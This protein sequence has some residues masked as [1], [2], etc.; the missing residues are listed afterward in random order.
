MGEKLAFES[1]FMIAEGG[2]IRYYMCCD[3]H[4]K[5]LREAWRSSAEDGDGCG[6]KR[7]FNAIYDTRVDCNTVDTVQRKHRHNLTTSIS[8]SYRPFHTKPTLSR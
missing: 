4:V 3:R 5:S 6:L 8:M 7:S 2:G 1:R